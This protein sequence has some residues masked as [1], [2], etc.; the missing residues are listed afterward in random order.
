MHIY[1]R[2]IFFCWNQLKSVAVIIHWVPCYQYWRLLNGSS[3]LFRTF[4]PNKFQFNGLY[5]KI[6]QRFCKYLNQ[7]FWNHFVIYLNSFKKNFQ[8]NVGSKKFLSVLIC[9]CHEIYGLLGI[10]HSLKWMSE[11]LLI[12]WVLGLFYLWLN[13]G[14]FEPH[15]SFW[16]P[17]SQKTRLLWLKLKGIK[18]TFW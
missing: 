10:F 1:F 8:Q 15:A 18:V 12:C 9:A 11:N 17:N 14:I 5:S 3:S 4:F 7:A 6:I 2:Y 13:S 16:A